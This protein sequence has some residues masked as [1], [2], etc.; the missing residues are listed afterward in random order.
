MPIGVR[1]GRA[2]FKR[3]GVKILIA[4]TQARHT[5]L[6]IRMPTSTA[7]DDEDDVSGRLAAG[8]VGAS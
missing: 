5:Y 6:H 7:D 4:S 3:L 1:V 2:A 8:T